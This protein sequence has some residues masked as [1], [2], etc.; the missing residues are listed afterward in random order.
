MAKWFVHIIVALLCTL[1]SMVLAQKTWA[2]VQA[3]K[4]S[5]Y[6]GEPIRLSVIVYTSTWFTTSPRFQNLSVPNAFVI[7]F[8]RTISGMRKVG[9]KQYASLEYTYQV[10]PY[11]SG[12][13]EVPSF[14]I[15]IESPS[16]G[17]YKGKAITL[18]TES[19]SINVKDIPKGWPKE[20]EWFTAQ[21]VFVNDQWNTNADT[22]KVGEL[23]TRTISLNAKGTMPNFIPSVKL[24][25]G[26]GYR[27]YQQQTKQLDTRTNQ[28]ANGKRIEEW[29]YLFE[30]PGQYEIPAYQ[31]HWFSPV[32]QKI[33]SKSSKS[34]RVVVIPNDELNILQ[35][36]IDSLSSMHETD[37]VEGVEEEIP[38]ETYL[39]WLI[40]LLIGYV[41]TR[42]IVTLVKRLT[43]RILKVYNS[44]V[45]QKKRVKRKLIHSK[46]QGFEFLHE[47]LAFCLEFEKVPASE[48][49][50]IVSS[51]SSWQKLQRN[52]SLTIS[53]R[54]ELLACIDL[55]GRSSQLNYL[56]IN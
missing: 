1:P 51:K 17:D 25:G 52:K 55:H 31:M 10:F 29:L 9:G 41:V 34:H 2:T 47:F 40:A 12:E 46:S 26:S 7:S 30:Q 13:L 18:E 53:E 22:L 24:E 28:Q 45:N 11:S 23:L 43:S 20:Y 4:H 14:K 37:R 49:E 19:I 36:R 54:R 42:V 16:E 15:D 33:M 27:V 50:K 35:T 21:N 32:Q 48:V 3:N 38:W 44:P 8:K 39:K 5:V 56:T 6:P